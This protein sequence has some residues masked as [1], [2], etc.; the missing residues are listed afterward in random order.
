MEAFSP[1]SGR[2]GTVVIEKIQN[3]QNGVPS[4]A[5]ASDGSIRSTRWWAKDGSCYRSLRRRQ[6]TVVIE[7]IQNDQTACPSHA[8]PTVD[9]VCTAPELNGM[10][11]L[12]FLPPAPRGTVVIEKIQNDQNGVVDRMRIRRFDS[13]HH[14]AQAGQ[15]MKL[16]SFL[17]RR[18]R[19]HCRHRRSEAD[20]TGVVDRM[21]TD[22]SILVCT[23]PKLGKG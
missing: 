12:S 2:R 3:D 23:A 20:K 4:I 13:G 10:K 6:D 16:L 19:G 11:L 18:R 8:H 5:C 17:L 21:R 9:S 14:R 1:S 22:G 15:R 7:K